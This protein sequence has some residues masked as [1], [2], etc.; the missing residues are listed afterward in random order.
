MKHATPAAQYI[1]AKV[2]D[3]IRMQTMNSCQS[4]VTYYATCYRVNDDGTCSLRIP[5]AVMRLPFPPFES[6]Y[7]RFKNAFHPQ[8]FKA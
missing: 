3:K 7:M 1:P 4:I 6:Q 2:G 5:P 8:S